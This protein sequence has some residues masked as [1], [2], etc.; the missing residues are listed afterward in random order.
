MYINREIKLHSYLNILE[1]ILFIFSYTRHVYAVESEIKMK[2]FV[3]CGR[4]ILTYLIC[5]LHLQSKYHIILKY[6]EKTTRQ[7]ISILHVYYV[8]RMTHFII[9][10][11]LLIPIKNDICDTPECY[12]IGNSL[13]SN[14]QLFHVIAV[15]LHCTYASFQHKISETPLIWHKIHATTSTNSYAG[16]GQNIIQT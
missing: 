12:R 1:I 7:C 3:F 4:P 10:D 14:S 16:T 11:T 9:L 8:F 6:S 2:N 15:K 13:Q 5:T